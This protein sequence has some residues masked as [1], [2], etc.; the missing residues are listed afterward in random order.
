MSISACCRRSA[1]RSAAPSASR[2]SPGARSPTSR[3]GSAPGR[4]RR[5]GW[6]TSDP[7]ESFPA[8]P[9]QATYWHTRGEQW[10]ANQPSI[11]A[12]LVAVT[13]ALF[14]RAAARPGERAL[15]IGCGTG[16]TTIEL[17][18]QV[19]GRGA[20]LAA[21]ISAPMLAV[22]RQRCAEQGYRHVRLLHV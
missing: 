5:E 17:A 20:V 4:M 6:M 14:A 9:D 19:G 13:Q 22:A 2:R 18:A 7:A 21:D 10:V 3:P 11:D 1:V 15:D 12:R 16:T 8:N